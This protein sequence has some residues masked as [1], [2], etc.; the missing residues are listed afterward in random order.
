MMTVSVVLIVISIATL[1]VG[2]IGSNDPIIYISITSAALAL[3]LLVLSYVQERRMR[4]QPATS[5]GF[6]PPSVSP[7]GRVEEPV[8]VAFGAAAEDEEQEE[9]EEE[10]FE[11]EPAAVPARRSTLRAKPR[12]SARPKPKAKAAARPKAKTKPKAKARPAAA[13]KTRAR[14]KTAARPKA[15]TAAKRKTR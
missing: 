15:K 14:A 10:E 7:L 12:T 4:A 1:I 13:P 6:S 2:W 5:G 11:P 9:E 3:I 8:T